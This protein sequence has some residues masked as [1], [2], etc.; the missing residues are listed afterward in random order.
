MTTE[1]LLAI[2]ESLYGL[3]QA[4]ENQR[5]KTVYDQLQTLHSHHTVEYAETIKAQRSELTQQLQNRW[6]KIAI[7][8]PT[9]DDETALQTLSYW[10]KIRYGWTIR[11]LRKEIIAYQQLPTQSDI[12]NNDERWQRAVKRTEN[13]IFDWLHE[14]INKQLKLPPIGLEDLSA[15]AL[16]ILL[17]NNIKCEP[18][19]ILEKWQQ[20]PPWQDAE[21]L[22][23]ALAGSHW[24]KWIVRKEP[25]PLYQWLNLLYQHP[26]ATRLTIALGTANFEQPDLQS[27]LNQLKEGKADKLATQLKNAWEAAQKKAVP[28]AR[29]FIALSDFDF[30]YP[31]FA[32]VQHDPD[33]CH[34]HFQNALAAVILGDAPQKVR[35]AL[36]TWLQQQGALDKNHSVFDTIEALKHRFTR[37]VTIYE[38]SYPPLG[39]TVHEWAKVLLR[40]VLE[41]EPEPDILWQLLER[42]R[43]G[44][45][46]L[47]MTLPPEWDKT[48]GKAL[49]S[50]LRKTIDELR[51]GYIPD[52]NEPWLPIEIWL[53]QFREWMEN[54][55]PTVEA[56]QKQLQPSEALVQ[57]FFDPVQQRLR[58]LWLDK[59]SF[60]IKNLSNNAALDSLW[61]KQENVIG[62]W[63]RCVKKIKPELSLTEISQVA[64]DL[65]KVMESE[66]VQILADTLSEWAAELEQLT[67]I[68]PAPLGQL[69]WESLPQ[70]EHK[71]VREISIAH[72][73]KSPSKSPSE[74]ASNQVICDPNGE[75]FCMI[76]EGQWVAKRWHTDLQSPCPSVF[77]ALQASPTV[78]KSF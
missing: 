43:I 8:P 12:A 75:K 28:L 26:C 6:Q 60:E 64:R 78:K 53:Y 72:W 77:D 40:E 36:Q 31:L 58:V 10:Q 50:A 74:N 48:L 45:N 29:L 39:D 52:E 22:Q 24:E 18:E 65:E 37:A 38:P 55:P 70:L 56:C 15:I 62:E 34:F 1:T 71:L 4:K 25:P 49:W 66:P 61:L 51:G 73:L 14:A 2:N 54:R 42:A 9:L 76:K 16:G 35:Q 32:H 7:Q 27:W 68:F 19:P 13:A 67:I 3:E 11:Q 21:S 23:T 33:D 20:H 69:P 17:V 41:K 47:T 63:I 46:S 59:N 5:L 44:L 30:H 57:P